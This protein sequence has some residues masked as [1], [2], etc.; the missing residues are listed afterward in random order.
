MPSLPVTGS[1]GRTVL[2]ATGVAA[3]GVGAYAIWSKRRLFS[4]N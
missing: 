1:T 4:R 2:G 3:V